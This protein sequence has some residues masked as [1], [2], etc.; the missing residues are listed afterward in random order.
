[1]AKKRILNFQL[2]LFYS[3]SHEDKQHKND[4]EK[5]LAILKRDKLLNEWSDKEIL[6]GQLISKEIK[7]NMREADIIVFLFSQNF[8]ASQECMNEW[9][10]A[11]KISLDK[12]K[13]FRVPV[14]LCDCPWKDILKDDNI[15]SLPNDGNPVANFSNKET[16]WNQIYEGIKNIINELRSDFT[17]NENF[18]KEIEKTDFLSE[19]Q[20]KLKNIFIFLPLLN[21]RQDQEYSQLREER[22][23][24]QGRL[25]EERITSQ[26]QLFNKKYTIIHGEE[27]SGKTALSRYLF[28]CL[29]EQLVPVLHINMDDI[30]KQVLQVDFLKKVYQDQFNGDYDLWVK[31]D[32]KVLILDDLHCKSNM[33]DFVI[34]SKDIFDKIIIMV[35]SDIF[36][37]FFKDESRLADFHQLEIQPMGHQQ[38]ENLI[39][40]RLKLSD[41]KA[42][43]GLID[44]IEERVN[45]IIIF[46]KFVPRYPFFVLSI[47]QTY[48]AFMPNNMSITS[49]GH[50]YNALIISFLIKSGVQESD[51]DIN[52]CFNFL[53][54]LAFKTYKNNN[55]IHF[56]NFIREYDN[57]FIIADS[58]INRLKSN[59]YGVLNE[60][61]SFKKKYIYYFF[62]GRFLSKNKEYEKIIE[63]MCEKSYLTSNY[64]TLLFIIHHTDDDKIIDDILL[65]TMCTIDSVE[66]ATLDCKETKRFDKILKT[67]QKNILSKGS[68]SSERRR[69]RENRDISDRSEIKNEKIEDDDPCN[70]I[71]RIFKNNEII[72]QV[73]RNKYGSMKRKQIEDIIEIIGD[74]GLRLINIIL[75]DKEEI[76]E[77]ALCIKKRGTDISVNKIKKELQFF[78]FIWAM[79]NI[80][81]IVRSINIPEIKEAIDHVVSKKS[82]SAYDLIGYFNQLDRSES[83]GEREKK[84]LSSLLKKHDNNNFIKKVIS[85]RTQHYMNTHRTKEPIQQGVCSLLNIKYTQ[86]ALHQIEEKVRECR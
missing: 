12:K 26:D 82:T 66:P 55:K 13:F 77:V 21:Y 7:K 9:E 31:K 6:P 16:A 36:N 19:S 15:K 62:L 2:K 73:L 59:E 28:L 65:R 74:S 48:E 1:M 27:M 17:P 8:I 24:S 53:E 81:K 51:K 49:Y 83:F 45:S 35:S 32:K 11:K 54:N 22:T 41:M 25:R 76:D 75:K 47:L 80:E 60:E 67:C 84:A 3:Y 57:Q 39:K 71:Y 37:S 52:T 58:I 85:L 5:A 68:V 56:D 18:L 50:C 20:I 34:Q 72:G 79:L 78:S 61:G 30:P 64:L 63:N 40:K 86:R 14:I 42:E 46:N 29:V 44:Q 23:T 70:Y 10:E 4:M 69:E 43:D 33:I 38:Q